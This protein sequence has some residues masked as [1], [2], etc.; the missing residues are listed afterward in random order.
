MSKKGLYFELVMSQTSN[1][2]AQEEERFYTVPLYPNLGVHQ[3]S[4]SSTYSNNLSQTKLTM[5]E[6]NGTKLRKKQKS[7]FRYEKKI[8]PYHRPEKLWLLAASVSQI[9]TS[10]MFPCIGLVFCEIFNLIDMEEADGAYKINESLKFMG[11]LLAMALINM[12][13]NLILSYGVY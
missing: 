7:F 11:I 4:S 3:S 10:V 5:N 1:K 12:I 2:E 9:V 13:A 6:T 8:S